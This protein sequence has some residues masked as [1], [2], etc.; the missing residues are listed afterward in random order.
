MNHFRVGITDEFDGYTQKDFPEKQWSKAI[1]Y[2]VQQL[3]AH[4][5]NNS[6]T[7]KLTISIELE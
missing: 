4:G 3:I 5:E 1:G 6:H 7:R 2:I